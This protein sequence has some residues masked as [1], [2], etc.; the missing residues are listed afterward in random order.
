MPLQSNVMPPKGYK[1]AGELG[2]DM[3][4]GSSF[5]N[6]QSRPWKGSDKPG[7]GEGYDF[8]SGKQPNPKKSGA[9]KEGTARN[10]TSDED[11]GL[12]KNHGKS[13]KY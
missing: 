7:Q 4:P 11:M 13:G 3:K 10:M 12:I 8:G 2:P 5:D 1:P 9:G 6:E